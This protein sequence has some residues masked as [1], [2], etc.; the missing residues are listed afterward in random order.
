MP[1]FY[2]LL[3]VVVAVFALFT[4]KALALLGAL[5]AV[6]FLA[7]GVTRAAD[8]PGVV[9]A[10]VLA[11]FCLLLGAARLLI[12]RVEQLRTRLEGSVGD[13][14]SVSAETSLP[15]TDFQAR[16]V[17]EIAVMADIARTIGSS[18]DLTNTLESILTSTRRLVA[19]DMAEITLWD[20]DQQQLVSHGALDAEAYHAEAGQV[21]QIGEGYSGW[22]AEHRLPLLIDDVRLRDDVRPKV[23]SP[24]SRL[25]S[26]LGIP[27]ERKGQFIGTLELISFHPASF[28]LHDEE[29]LKEVGLQAAVAIE[30]ARFYQEAQQRAA[31][32]SA[33]AD[34]SAAIIST[35]DH[36]QI[37]NTIVASVLDLVHCQRSVI[38]VRDPEE[39]VLRLAASHGMS[40]E[41]VASSQVLEME[42]HGRAHAAA[43]GAAL[44]VEDVQSHPEVLSYAPMA[45]AEGFRAFADLPLTVGDR[46]VGM[47]SAIFARPHRFTELER[48][49]LAALADQ[50]A[51]A[52]ENASLY[53]RVD[54]ELNRR[55][56]ALTGL[57]RIARELS[58]T[59][60]QDHILRLVLEEAILLSAAARAAI[61]L[62]EDGA[63]D[64]QLSLCSGY[65][66]EEQAALRQYLRTSFEGSPIGTVAR[67]GRSLHVDISTEQ[68][69][70]DGLTQT[71]TALLVPVWYSEAPTAVI[72]LES[73][74]T[75][76]F[77]EDMQNFIDGL[78]AQAAIAIGNARRY[79]DE[80]ARSDLLRRRA[81]QLRGILEV[82]Q[83]IRSDQ[84]LAEVLEDIAYAVQDS[85]GFDVALIN[86]VE[87]DPPHLSRVAAAGLPI[88]VFE[89]LKSTPQPF[90]AWQQ[91]VMSEA[92]RVSQS[93]YVPAEQQVSLGGAVDTY[94][95][96]NGTGVVRE[97]GMWHPQDMLIVPFLG[98]GGEVR[99]TLSV[100]AP[101]D[102][103]APSRD[104]IEVLEVFADQAAVA[105]ENAQLV[106][107]LQRRLELLT[108]FNEL[109]RS[110]T[111]NLDLS[112]VLNTVVEAT[113]RLV[114]CD[115]SVF[116]LQDQESGQY[117]PMAA[118]GHTLKR[119]SA[120]HADGAGLVEQAAARRMPLNLA[121]VATEAHAHY[122]VS[123]GAT[124][125]IPLEIG[126]NVVG[127]LTADREQKRA[128]SPTDVATLIALADQV[129]L[130][131]QSARLFDESVR[132][133]N[134]LSVLL[135][136]NSAISS[137]LDLKWMLQA[138]GDRLLNVTGAA[139]CHL[140]EWDRE[141]DLVSVVWEVGEM[142]LS[143]SRVG[144]TFTVDHRPPAM[145]EVLLI[146]EA[147]VLDAEELW[148]DT[149]TRA[150]ERETGS[151]LLLPMVARGRTV[152]L[153]ELEQLA[154]SSGSFSADVVRLA[155]ALAN[156]A[157]VAIENAQLFE[158]TRRFSE[159]LEERVQERTEE[160]AQT[161]DELTTERDRVETLYRIASEL[162]SSLDMDQI[163]TRTLQ[164]VAEAVSASQ[165]TILLRDLETD[166]LYRRAVVGAGAALPPGGEES[167][168]PRGQ[169]LGWWVITHGQSLIVDDL[170]ADERWIPQNAKEEKERRSCLA[171]PLGTAGEV[172]G[173]LL[174]YHHRKGFFA[175]DHL[176]LVEAIGSQISNT[177]GN[178]ALY[179]LIRDQAEQ[180][181]SMLK[182][183]R[184]E[185][186]KSQAIL[187]GV[188]DG[189]MV[190]DA[191][192]RVIL[193]N[194]AAEQIL[195]IPRQSVLGRSTR[196]MLGLYGAEGRAWMEA[197]NDWAANPADRAPGD[198]TAEQ[199]QLGDRIVSIHVSP[200]IMGTEYL[201]TVSVFRD[202]TVVV[203][204]DRAKSEF[205]STVSHELRTPMT[206]IKGYAD[207]LV[208]GAVGQ[209]GE[210][211][212]H[213]IN[214][215][216]NNADR[217]TTL[218]NDL[219]DIS[220]IETGRVELSL[221]AVSIA[222]VVDLV[223]N[224]LKG[225]AEERD[226]ALSADVPD[227]LPAVWGDNHR[228]NQILT[229][230]TG[231]AIQ[232]T[233][234]GGSVTISARVNA[235][236]LEVAVSDT[237][238][239]ISK[240]NI[241]K[242]FD[243]F[244]RVDDPL[245][246]ETTGTGLGLAIT[247]SLVHMHGGEIWVESELGQGSTFWFSLPLARFAE[248]NDEADESMRVL[249]EEIDL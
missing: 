232:Y 216:R 104:T 25:R 187:E 78:A 102:G 120:R 56:V 5:V 74:E 66:E 40:E 233:P 62:K 160:L 86:I 10:L 68:F 198:F 123:S 19:F 194:A 58:T 84:P 42:A 159:E 36:E 28:T 106:E 70:L 31:E 220:R 127:V 128:F 133:T 4:G 14:F 172:Q 131:V 79:Q 158:K 116:F 151:V 229:N 196:E 16:R 43:T 99:G 193:F 227:G 44:I 92:F 65:L 218:V 204:A 64:W 20:H 145:T 109:N 41:Y 162:S 85:V 219:L 3:P 46:V 12:E 108:F 96:V 61:I 236:R 48:D 177:I 55:A 222:E 215:I 18:L 226:L 195:D 100:D 244:F 140:S 17:E 103:R 75:D 242:I 206:S 47:L 180:L 225:R 76:A 153:V 192:G 93:Y 49:I 89:R 2:V 117:V 6:G 87:G 190:A 186:A 223:V 224:T 157:A 170:S 231:N 138:L 57:Q 134:E 26:Y 234:S 212:L 51:L 33:L 71:R 207:L 119:L 191:R 217:L 21:Y 201:G 161:L 213:F 179:N 171:I 246:Q 82:G 230:L 63:S 115:G 239:G 142:D 50:A 129:A 45:E 24:D 7:F 202:I 121:D 38:F 130:A 15:V 165:G 188:A 247:A 95:L 27:L 90:A 34:V 107:A 77:D 126:G 72:M 146:Q 60:D 22:L 155:Q 23:Y 143:H 32:L 237:G 221:K 241:K 9:Y 168:L 249:V 166:R 91:A 101:R 81:D 210:Q 118:H 136:A 243:R 156:Q 13:W 240:E 97:P 169:G 94:D 185:S 73:A 208:M 8:V 11:L 189:V 181:G 52:I 135:E 248:G 112:K 175:E 141:K 114:Q 152:G 182:Q 110:V 245:V 122:Y 235:D 69:V 88:D 205:V 149:A 183:Q 37:L 148:R 137:T 228:I 184:V 59:F 176:R 147:L 154:E 1:L 209:L 178:A 199:I 163:L 144:A 214:I 113:A 200:F 105:I 167:T 211:Q 98:H 197:I 35:L 111:A 173:A 150:Q 139:R 53:A 29:V 54:E 174:L 238:I 67:T 30:N 132:R 164:Q 80:I 125:L 39:D 83:V 203:E 124:I